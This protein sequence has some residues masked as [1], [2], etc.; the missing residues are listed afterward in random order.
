MALS[1]DYRRFMGELMKKTLPVEV[2]ELIPHR[3]PMRVVDRLLEINGKD[4]VVEAVIAA[5]CPLV[6]IDGRLEDAALTELLAQAYAAVKGYCDLIEDKP[7]R[8]GF[9]VGIKKVDRLLSA[10]AGDRLKI[11]IYTL[12][13]LDDFAVA[14]GEIW[15]DEELLARGE[16]KVW[17][18]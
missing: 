13:E 5:D 2:E 4:G 17:V 12:V 10:R 3:L 16:I 14:A 6:S 8:Q 9:L 7:I 11:N 18:H 15:C 1:M